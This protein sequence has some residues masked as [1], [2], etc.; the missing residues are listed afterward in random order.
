MLTSADHTEHRERFPGPGHRPVND[1]AA[2]VARADA[3]SELQVPAEPTAADAAG[4]HS[5]A[6]LLPILAVVATAFLII[7][8]ALPVLPLHVHQRLGLGTF[9][10]GLVTGG[11]FAASLFSRMIA[12]HYADSRGA[13]G[14][15]IIGLILAVLSGLLYLAS[16]G[17][18][19]APWLS[20]SILLAGRAV[21]GGAESFIITGAA[22]WG[23][24]LAGPG[25]AGRVI[26]WVG[27]AMFVAMALGAPVGSAL[28]ASGGLAAVA[29]GTTVIPVA[30]LLIVAP[31]RAVPS[32]RA[33]PAGFLQVAGAVWLPGVGSALSSIGFGAIL[34]FSPLLAAERGWDPVWLSFSAFALALVAARLFLGHMPDRIGGAR[35]ALVCVL[36]EALGLALLWFSP[37]RIMAAAGAAL[38]GFGYSLVYP[39]L[40]VE[41]VRRAPRQ[42][43]GLAMGAYTV[44]LDVTL[45]FGSPALGLIAGWRGLGAVFVASAAIVCCA[46][47]IAAR[48]LIASSSGNEPP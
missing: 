45:G 33:A 16:L 23:F 42:R 14:A 22:A 34:A 4:G 19:T 46:A 38:T 40:G 31:L 17:F 24:V 44:F 41:A 21:L 11:Q 32:S 28:Y 5:L 2:I 8:I 27:M 12:G 3:N 20:V 37:G 43:R 9:V 6:A 25:N 36:I 1:A 39:G 35:V 15:V 30:T 47:G 10:V 29:A 26:A 48:L 13:K 18:V 7:G